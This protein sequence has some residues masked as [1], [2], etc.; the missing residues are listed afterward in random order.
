MKVIEKR[1]KS[2]GLG[3]NTWVYLRI[4]WSCHCSKLLGNDL[5]WVRWIFKHFLFLQAPHEWV[6]VQREQISVADGFRVFS[7]SLEL[8]FRLFRKLFDENNSRIKLKC[9]AHIREVPKAIRE[10]V[11]TIH[12]PSMDELTNQKLITWNAAGKVEF[13]F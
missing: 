1:Y 10:S 5:H 12:V 7:R 4:N 13:F 8:R 3:P 11:A 9:V 6:Q 2:K